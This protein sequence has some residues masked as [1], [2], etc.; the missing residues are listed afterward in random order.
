ME[1]FLPE[2]QRE[3]TTSFF[4]GGDPLFD[5]P[6]SDIWPSTQITCIGPTPLVLTCWFHATLRNP[7]QLIAYPGSYSRGQKNRKAWASLELVFCL[8][9]LAE[10]SKGSLHG[11]STLSFAIVFA[12]RR[13]S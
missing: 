6:P 7:K 1:I 12:S 3:T 10:L 9:D 11:K 5:D 2:N 13:S 4:W 8:F